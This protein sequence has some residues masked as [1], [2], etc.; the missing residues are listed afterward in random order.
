MD[1]VNFGSAGLRVS[2]IALGLALRGQPDAAVAQ[3]MVGRALD[4]GVNLIDCAN[5]YS[6]MDHPD[7]FGASEEI[8][9]RALK[10]RRDRVVITSKV[11]SRIGPGPNDYGSSRLHITREVENSLRRLNTDYIDVYLL[12]AF[13]STTPL[14]ETVR[15]MDDLVHSGKVRYIGCCNFRAWQ[16]CK[17]LWVADRLLLH[18]IHVR[19]EPVQSVEPP[20]GRRDL[21]T[22]PRPGA[23]RH[24]L[25][26]TGCWTAWRRI[27]AGHMRGG[28]AASGEATARPST[29][30]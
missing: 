14:E 8:L 10:G 12:H 9:G 4:L 22:R 17:A 6:P 27:W 20:T 26:A 1:Y 19:T 25:R 30:A 23:G 13:D 28:R 15:T 29:S 11:Q 2:P 21:R 5:R 16:V 18:A 3:R 24:G 7:G